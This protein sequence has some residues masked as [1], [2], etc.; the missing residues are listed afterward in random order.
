M[1]LDDLPDSGQLSSRVGDLLSNRRLIVSTIVGFVAV[2]VVFL[3]VMV[4]NEV[5]AQNSAQAWDEYIEIM[6]PGIADAPREE[7]EE[8]AG[9]L[10][11]LRTDLG[12]TPVMPWILKD[13]GDVY[14]ALGDIPK[15]KEVFNRLQ[16]DYPSHVAV[17]GMLSLEA[18]LQTDN[19]RDALEDCEAQAAFF[20]D[21]P[22]R[23]APA[24][25]EEA[26][27]PTEPE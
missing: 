27:S 3:G 7:I 8:Y 13:L 6:D 4:W 12:G 2:V 17:R 10:E 9:K 25:E 16:D 11:G 23:P 5:S 26:A 14:F 18:S 20:V 1:K 24:P 22:D 21:H 15:A 19:V